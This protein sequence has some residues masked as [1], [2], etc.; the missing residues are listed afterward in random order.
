MN[1]LSFLFIFVFFVYVESSCYSEIPPTILKDTTIDCNHITFLYRAEEC[2]GFSL[3]LHGWVEAKQMNCYDRISC[4][5]LHKTDNTDSIKPDSI[6]VK[7]KKEFLFKNGIVYETNKKIKGRR[8]NEKFIFDTTI[9]DT[10][11]QLKMKSIFIKDSL[12][13]RNIEIDTI[14]HSTHH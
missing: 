7:L 13:K 1:K 5:N 11:Y 10:S 12:I 2:P 9:H 4:K 3:Q 8:Y 14:V 6:K